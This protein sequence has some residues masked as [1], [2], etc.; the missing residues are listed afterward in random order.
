MTT[1]KQAED[2][3]KEIYQLWDGW[4]R[5]LVKAE[6]PDVD[7]KEFTKRMAD[8]I[9]RA[10]GQGDQ[11]C[12]ASFDRLCELFGLVTER[13]RHGYVN[14]ETTIASVFWRGHESSVA[15][16]AGERAGGETAWVSVADRLPERGQVV[17]VVEDGQ[18]TTNFIPYILKGFESIPHYRDS[19]RWSHG[20]SYVT[21][22][23]PLP[24][25]PTA[26]EK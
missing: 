12:G 21:H 6:R 3:S 18:V 15:A 4:I 20:N 1:R 5:Q 23:Q 9:E 13:D 8:I 14:R 16:K 19:Y 2:A 24:S 17:L 26:E 11:E 22:W 7:V 25:P 10:S